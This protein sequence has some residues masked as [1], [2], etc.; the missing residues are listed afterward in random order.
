M[1]LSDAI[2]IAGSEPG[3][4]GGCSCKWCTSVRV[5]IDFAK[6]TKP[7]DGMT[8]DDCEHGDDSHF[9]PCQKCTRTGDLHDFFSQK[10]PIVKLV[11]NNGTA[12]ERELT[13]DEIDARKWRNRPRVVVVEMWDLERRC[14]G[15]FSAGNSVEEA[16]DKVKYLKEN[17]NLDKTRIIDEDGD[18]VEE[19]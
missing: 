17:F 19:A 3:V 12:V 15:T 11:G 4:E 9:A 8:C 16:R 5:L 2:R 6:S 1:S 13:Q 7:E 18:I 14:W 10:S